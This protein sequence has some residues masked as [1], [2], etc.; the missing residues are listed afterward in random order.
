MKHTAVTIGPIYKTFLNVR[1]TREVWAASYMFSF[2][3]KTIIQELV[4]VGI[5]KTRFII[6]AVTDVALNYKGAG[7]FP[8]RIIFESEN[9]DYAKVNGAIKEA[10]KIFSGYFPDDKEKVYN[11]LEEYFRFYFLEKE[12]ENGSNFIEDLYLHMDTLE[13]QNKPLNEIN[14]NKDY[15]FDFFRGINKNDFFKTNCYGND[16]N[17][18]EELKL[19]DVNKK[20]RF[21]SLIEISTRDL[22]DENEISSKSNAQRTFTYRE[23]INEFLWNDHEGDTDNDQ[24]FSEALKS[25]LPEKF[26]NYHKY[27]AILKADGDKIGSTIKN[28]KGDV[29]K[30][31]SFSSD[32]L[33]WAIETDKITRKYGGIPI[34][35][36]GDDVLLFAPVANGNRTFIDLVNDIDSAF[37]ARFKKYLNEKNEHPTLSYGIAINYYK[38][39]LYEAIGKVDELLYDA[40]NYSEARNSVC[41]RVLKHSGSELKTVFTK[42][43]KNSK[44]QF[45]NIINHL[46]ADKFD[47][48]FL[49][50]VAYK[51]RDNEKVIDRLGKNSNRIENFFDNN[52][53]DYNR[54]T[55][56]QN[57]KGK[58]LFAV[59]QLLINALEESEE[60][61]IEYLKKNP[62]DEKMKKITISE[63]A[64]EKVYTTLKISRFIKGMDDEK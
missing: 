10:V 40:K 22:R 37:V 8:D 34:Y 28:M 18:P 62:E 35:I 53:D 55:E 4:S 7:L 41:V 17:V 58:Y 16:D 38:F 48:S 6:P 11:Y 29:E 23:L 5:D 50:S 14:A 63:L 19:L 51:L 43:G 30:L 27:I 44:S 56:K 54:I 20:Q 59:K 25:G 57:K 1:K 42:S 47:K 61:K 33:E 3:M 2:L 52:Y 13:L 24:G 32:L 31:K 26:K 15:L 39:P 49:S 21:E 9:E 64:L 60:I 46:D 45:E 12:L 36:G